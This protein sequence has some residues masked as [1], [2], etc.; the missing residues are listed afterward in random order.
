MRK[1]SLQLKLKGNIK[2]VGVLFGLMT[3]LFAYELYLINFASPTLLTIQTNLVFK[4][5]F[6]ITMWIISFLTMGLSVYFYYSLHMV[7][8]RMQVV[9]LMGTGILLFPFSFILLVTGFMIMTD[10]PKTKTAGMYI[11]IFA[12][13]FFLIFYALTLVDYTEHEIVYTE[14][15][16]YE[17]EYIVSGEV[18]LFDMEVIHKD[19][20]LVKVTITS[21][22][23]ARSPEL[24][25]PTATQ[26][27][28]QLKVNNRGTCY[29]FVT[30]DGVTN[31]VTSCEMT[32]ST[33]P[34]TTLGTLLNFDSFSLII[35]TYIDGAIVQSDGELTLINEE[36]KANYYD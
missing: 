17:F 9:M 10:R 25:A 8:N 22:T 20:E 2:F 28:Y 6:I 31:E 5:Y 11:T 27:T 33:H 26:L 23:T 19:G 18:I 24:V 13:M 12:G 32:S 21:D 1:D 4:D 7:S 30:T 16:I 14:A 35:G 15:S 3:I 29:E 34:N 36:V